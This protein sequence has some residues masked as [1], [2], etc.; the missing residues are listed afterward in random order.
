MQLQVKDLPKVHTWQLEHY[1]NLRPSGLKATSPTTSDEFLA[2]NERV[3]V[4]SKCTMQC[5]PDDE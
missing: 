5:K 2:P 4:N 3:T 1:S